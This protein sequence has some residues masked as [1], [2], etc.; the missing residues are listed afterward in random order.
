MDLIMFVV[1]FVAGFFTPI[2]I[3][4]VYGR[5]QIHEALKGFK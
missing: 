1:G 2:I 4:I 3:L 5:K